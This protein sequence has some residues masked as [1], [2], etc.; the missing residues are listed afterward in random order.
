MRSIDPVP[1]TTTFSKPSMEEV[2]QTI[3]DESK[4]C[5]KNLAI[6][7]ALHRD[8]EPGVV[9]SIA[10][11]STASYSLIDLVASSS[12]PSMSAPAVIVNSPV[13]VANTPSNQ[14]IMGMP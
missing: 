13:S 1:G 12:T 9:H 3:R 8:V 4:K 5:L 6:N 14:G 2:H 7:P 11:A 10:E